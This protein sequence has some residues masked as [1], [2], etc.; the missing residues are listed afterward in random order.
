MKDKKQNYTK[1]KS[2]YFIIR[3]IIHTFLDQTAV[4]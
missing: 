2:T 1:I 3:F 4:K